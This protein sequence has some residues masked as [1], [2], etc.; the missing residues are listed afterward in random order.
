MSR[1]FHVIAKAGVVFFPESSKFYAVPPETAGRLRAW[2]DGG[3]QLPAEAQAMV[4]AEAA[5]G[6]ASL[7]P[8]GCD[9]GDVTSLCLYTAHD[10]NLAC[11][12]CYNQ[13]GRAV[14]PFAM[15]SFETAKAAIDRF[16]QRPGVSYAV[17]LYGGEPLLNPRL[18]KPMVEYA[19]RLRQERDIRISFS[20]TTNGTVMNREILALLDRHFSSVTVSLDG[21]GLVNDLHRRYEKPCGHSAHDKAVETI[22]LLKEK[23]KLRVTVKGTL[24]AQGLPYY[25]E[26]LEYLQS[27]GA[28]GASLDPAFGPEDADWALA[29]EVFDRYA[30]MQAAD[31]ADDL[32]GLDEINGPWHEY[33]FQIVAGLLT[34][35]RLLRHCSIG[36]DLAVM[37]DGEIYACHGLA[38]LPAFHMGRVDDPASPDFQRL[39]RDFATVD[40]R[41]VEGCDTCWARYLC[42]GGCYANAWFR[43]GSVR[44]PDSRHCVVFKAV[45]ENVIA[46]FVETMAQ[47][48]R[49]Q[50]LLRKVRGMIGAAPKPHV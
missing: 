42:G 23:T 17:G 33:T 22:R 4:Q 12:Y 2:L 49:A 16:F 38:G 11:T 29:G 18:I 43:T 50:G 6:Q 45:A 32:A 10:C 44:R 1:D 37:A 35:R 25:R 20:V 30:A 19:E 26:S 27:L 34:R 7:Q 40:V 3:E 8:T 36:R 15:M 14:A 9:G 21:P 24:T 5:K 41:T 46:A 39:H 13:R 48:E 28:D 47:P 31:A